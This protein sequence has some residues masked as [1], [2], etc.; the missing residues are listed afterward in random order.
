MPIDFTG[1]ILLSRLYSI[2]PPVTIAEN[3]MPANSTNSS[4]TSSGYLHIIAIEPTRPIT[5]T[6]IRAIPLQGLNFLPLVAAASNCLAFG[7]ETVES[8][9][10]A[11]SSLIPELGSKGDGRDEL[12][13]GNSTRCPLIKIM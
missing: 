1:S 2:R 11:L 5:P 13:G 9:W 7:G 10:D 8:D 6:T 4:E 12:E 3:A